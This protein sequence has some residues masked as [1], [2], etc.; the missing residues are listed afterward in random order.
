MR[1]KGMRA[2]ELINEMQG[3]I[4]RK[5]ISCFFHSF[6]FSVSLK[7]ELHA[8]NNRRVSTFIYLFLQIVFDIENL[9][10]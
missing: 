2:V 3:E 6:I 4:F 5:K 7:R 10:Y 8:W 1:V 9:K